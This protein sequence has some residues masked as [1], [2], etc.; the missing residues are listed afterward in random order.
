MSPRHP[1]V[2]FSA[3]ADLTPDETEAI[4][5]LAEAPTTCA[6]GAIIRREGDTPDLHLLHSG[7]VAASAVSPDGSRQY[8]KVHMPGDVMGAPSLPFRQAVET[9]TALTDAVVARLSLS[10]LGRVFADHPRIGALMF[11]AAN[12]ERVILMDRLTAV[13]RRTSVQRLAALLLHFDERLTLIDRDRPSRFELPLTQEQI[14]DLIG[15]TP[16]H[17]NRVFRQLEVQGAI[18]RRGRTIEIPERDKLRRLAA[19]PERPVVRNLAW[20]PPSRG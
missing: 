18:H 7:W 9:L 20:L 2:R 12:E 16:V 6:K 1:V 17:V 15:L 4:K 13:A 5:R 19:L 10:A 8:F 11:L 3:L 14:G